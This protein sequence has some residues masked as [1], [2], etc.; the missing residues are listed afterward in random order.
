MKQYWRDGEE[1]KVASA[2]H[3]G[4]TGYQTSEGPCPAF[5]G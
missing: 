5:K 2:W 3:A 4:D 1:E